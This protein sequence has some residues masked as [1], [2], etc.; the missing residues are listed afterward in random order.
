METRNALITYN[1]CSIKGDISYLGTDS[2]DEGLGKVII[3]EGTTFTAADTTFIK[4]Y[5]KASIETYDGSTSG[6]YLDNGVTLK[7][8]GSYEAKKQ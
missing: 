1:N 6:V 2:T 7:G 4:Q 8:D 3:G 5:N